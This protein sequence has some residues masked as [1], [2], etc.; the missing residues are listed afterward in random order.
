MHKPEAPCKDCKEQK[1]L[2][3]STCE[4]YLDF[5]RKNDELKMFLANARYKE[6]LKYSRSIKKKK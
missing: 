1:M 4:R 5:K 3:H 6:N 2:C